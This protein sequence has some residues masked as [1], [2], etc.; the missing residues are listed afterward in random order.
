MGSIVE[1]QDW[2]FQSARIHVLNYINDA[3]YALK[4]AEVNG[5]YLK[6]CLDKSDFC[7]SPTFGSEMLS[8]LKENLLSQRM[9]LLAVGQPIKA[10]LRTPE[11]LEEQSP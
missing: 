5:I 3:S 4:V 6:K 2:E 11:S 1:N 7:W 9:V 10:E 8:I